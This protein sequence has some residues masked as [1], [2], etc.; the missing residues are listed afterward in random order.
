MPIRPPA[1]ADLTH[2]QLVDELVSRI[3]AHTPEWTNPRPGDPGRTLIDLFAWLGDALLYR[4]NLVPE[5]QRL[6]FLALLGTGM[7]PAVPAAGL[8]SVAFA[9]EARTAPAALRPF[10]A[11]PGKQP[12]ETTQELTVL[13]LQAECYAK[14]A[15]TPLEQRAQR[16]VISGLQ[17]VYGL[18][19]PPL[20]YVTTR[21]FAGAADEGFDLVGQTIDGSLW[22][23]LLAAK[24][25]LV[26]DVRRDIKAGIGGGP[27][28]ASVGLVPRI[29]MPERFDELRPRVPIPVAWEA[30]VEQGGKPQLVALEFADRTGGL[31]REGVMVLPLPTALPLGKPDNDPRKLLNAGVGDLP[32]RIDDPARDE[33]L[34]GWL[35]MRPRQSRAELSRLELAWAG[36]N[37]VELEQRQTL[38]PRILGTSDGTPGQVFRLPGPSVERA[39]LELEVEEGGRFFRWQCVD[40]FATLEADALAAREAR[41]YTLDA[42]AGTVQFGD[43]VRGRIPEPQARVRARRVRLGG[44]RAGNLAAGT[45]KSLNATDVEGR[46]L[47]GLKLHQPLPLHGGEDAETLAQAE[48]RIPAR[49]RHGDRVVTPEDYRRIAL[50]TPGADVARVELLPRFKPQQRRA[51]VPGVVSVM[52]LPARPLGPAPNPRAD[53]VFLETVHAHLDARRPLGAELYVIGCEYVPLAVSA[54]IGIR[55][56]YGPD[57]VLQA[58]R[59]ALRKLLWPLAPGGPAGE[60]WPL[61][62]AVRDQELEVEVS[63]VDGVARVA[64]IH[65]FRRDGE[66]WLALPALDACGTQELG[67]QPWQ[68]PEL[69]A[70]AAVAGDAAPADPGGGVPPAAGSNA[71]GVPVVPEVC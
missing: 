37:A 65:L 70:V 10:A 2:D 32:P 8:V 63:R 44:G 7:R 6:A 13:P 62:R 19:G 64:Q 67:L 51:D 41:A 68:L 47:A 30:C 27:A 29:R 60:G 24:R 54:A 38:G 52:A 34:V 25:E 66:R 20:P 46:A 9:E 33:R 26:A 3:P 12:F 36:L 5:R 42:E 21:L 11:V 23:A 48:A 18:D 43:N 57:T 28:R 61:G 53:R 40:D 56:G 16:E 35:R 17:T 55:E 49:L 39:T 45:L 71:V 69:L 14:R 59:E 1:I 22:I 50:H 4:A 31:Q 58:V 15:L